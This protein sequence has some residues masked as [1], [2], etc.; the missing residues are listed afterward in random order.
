[1]SQFFSEFYF[2]LIQIT[3]LAAL[4]YP[5]GPDIINGNW[6]LVNSDSYPAAGT[7]FVYNRGSG[8]KPEQIEARGP[9]NQ[10]VEI[11]VCT[12]IE[13]YIDYNT[14]AAGYR[15]IFNILKTKKV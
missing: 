8:S 6:R 5:D 11:M 7:E 1:M 2:W 15:A 14:F 13:S 10:S 9:T 4:K 3:F 12:N